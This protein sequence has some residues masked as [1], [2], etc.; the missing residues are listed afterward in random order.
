MNT[1]D[2]IASLESQIKVLKVEQSELIRHQAQV[3]LD[4]WRGRIDD[5]EVQM[6]LG[7]MEVDQ[8]LAPLLEKMQHAWTEAKALLDGKPSDDG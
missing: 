5:L 8:L 7:A 4:K 3:E 6:H 2:R 1:S